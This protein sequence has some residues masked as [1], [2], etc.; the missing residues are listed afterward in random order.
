[1][2]PGIRHG[3]N[4]ARSWGCRCDVCRTAFSA[5]VKEYNERAG[6]TRRAK[7]LN[8]RT[9]AEAHRHRYV[10]TGPELELITREGLTA[11]KCAET[12]GRTVAAVEGMRAHIASGEPKILRLLGK[13]P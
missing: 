6:Y 4:T 9:R 12:I 3:L 13:V 5:A 8:D 7:E 11:E 2:P 10:W 1:M